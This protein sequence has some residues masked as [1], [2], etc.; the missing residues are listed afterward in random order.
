MISK[1]CCAFMGEDCAAALPH[2]LTVG[3]LPLQT[4]PEYF[5]IDEEAV[6]VLGIAA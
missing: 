1:K 6:E 3:A 4:S 2:R 5:Q